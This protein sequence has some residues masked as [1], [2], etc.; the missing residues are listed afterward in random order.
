MN[1]YL[2]LANIGLI[3]EYLDISGSVR[4]DLSYLCGDIS[5]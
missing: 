5:Y 2:Y 3:C 4:Y 1:C